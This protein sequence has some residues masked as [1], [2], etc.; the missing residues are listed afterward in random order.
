MEPVQSTLVTDAS[1]FTIGEVFNRTFAVLKQN[2]LIFF[3][4]TLAAVIPGI[5]LSMLVPVVG[6]ILTTVLSLLVEAAIAIAVFQVLRGTK[7]SFG[8]SLSRGL[9]NLVAVFVAALLTGLGIALGTL[10]LV[11]PGIILSCIW[12]VTIPA[13]AVEQLGAIDSIKRSTE[14]TKG[15]RMT[16]FLCLLIFGVGM[17]ATSLL[18]VLLIGLMPT[19][20]V[21][22]VIVAILLSALLQAVASVMGSI[23]YYNLRAL[24]EGVTLDSLAQVFE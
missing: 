17:F 8:G 22:W 24:K 14:L 19:L 9:S 23:I 10:L 7:P 3:G 5:L 11:I 1:K 6:D 18:L 21:V 2:P 15:Y 12:V 13:C 4:L 20:I 16:I